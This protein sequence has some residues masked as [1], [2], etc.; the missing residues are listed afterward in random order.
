M[1][2]TRWISVKVSQRIAQITKTVALAMGISVSEF[3]RQAILEKLE[4]INVM[5]SEVKAALSQEIFEDKNHKK[6]R[7]AKN[8]KKKPSTA[9][10]TKK[11]RL[12]DIHSTNNIYYTTM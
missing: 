9:Y 6:H 10:K 2:K 1:C 11:R 8:R 3:T 5:S 12:L 4:R 7:G